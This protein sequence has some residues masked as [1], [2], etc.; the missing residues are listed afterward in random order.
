MANFDF[1]FNKLLK[2]EGGYV[3]DK[4]DKGGETKYGISK[5]A[6]QNIDI[7]NLTRQDAMKIYKRDYWD[8]IKGEQIKNQR[9]A[10]YLFDMAVNMGVGSASKIV[11]E[12][13]GV[14]VDGI[15]GR[16][17]LNA[18]N[19]YNPDMLIAEM[20]LKRIQRYINIVESKKTN[21]KFLLGWIKRALKV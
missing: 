3:D 8:K 17:T 18:I 20:R 15:V 9:V 19:S 16:K 21:K 14:K 13:V 4:D 2:F 5:N 7:E 10:E 6:Y 1:A 11:Q 12:I